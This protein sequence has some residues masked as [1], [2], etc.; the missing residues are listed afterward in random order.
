MSW[1][2]L[3]R[4]KKSFIRSLRVWRGSEWRNRVDAVLLSDVCAIDVYIARVAAVPWAL[5][6]VSKCF[7]KK[8]LLD[9]LFSSWFWFLKDFIFDLTPFEGHTKK[10][11]IRSLRVWHKNEWR[12]RVD[13]VL[14]SDVCAMD[15]YIAL[16]AAMPWALQVV[17]KY[18]RKRF[19]IY[20]HFDVVL[21]KNKF[22]DFLN[23]FLHAS[24]SWHRL[25]VFKTSCFRSS[26]WN[27][28]TQVEVR[29]SHTC[30][31]WLCDSV[32]QVQTV[33][34]ASVNFRI[35]FHF[36]F[37]FSLIFACKPFVIWFPL[38]AV[39]CVHVCFARSSDT[40]HVE[41]R[42]FINFCV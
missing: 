22:V 35:M 16:V 37:P 2:R 38:C 39:D 17:S 29:R 18:F 10:S 31:L 1:H 19:D 26:C 28:E 25:I 30:A 42:I 33:M 13:V 6:V 23:S 21:R 24:T 5:Q 7:R 41:V 32:G 3:D 12:K 11:F 9:F 27:L 8:P 20:F 15:V 4:A 34:E 40:N 36:D 14:L